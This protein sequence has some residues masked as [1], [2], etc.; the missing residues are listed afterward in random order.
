MKEII[1]MML[2]ACEYFAIVADFVCMMWER[3]V[4]GGSIGGSAG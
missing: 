4:A 1:V 2:S 3:Y